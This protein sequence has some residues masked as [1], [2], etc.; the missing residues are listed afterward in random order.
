MPALRATSC[1]P[2][3]DT[4]PTSTCPPTTRRCPAL[5]LN[6]QVNDRLT[7]KGDAYFALTASMLMAGGHLQVNW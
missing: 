2:S 1:S 7:I 5:G 6:W 4:T 3:A